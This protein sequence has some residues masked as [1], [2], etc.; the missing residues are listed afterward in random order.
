MVKISGRDNHLL[1]ATQ[2]LMSMRLFMFIS[3]CP[4][5]YQTVRSWCWTD[6][7]TVYRIVTFVVTPRT[8]ERPVYTFFA[9]M[10]T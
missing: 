10:D 3:R 2:V 5:F 9:I 1:L 6:G 8:L 7:D 4:E